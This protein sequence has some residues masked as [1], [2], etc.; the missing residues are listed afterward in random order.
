MIYN[1]SDAY[2][3]RSIENYGEFSESEVDVFREIL[4]SGDF[5]IDVGANIGCHT[6]AFQRLVGNTGA[7]FSFEPERNN[8]VTLCGNVA[9]NNLHNV[10]VYQKALGSTSGT[11]AVPEID[12]AKTTN[13]GS[14][15]LCHDYSGAVHYRV[16]VE[17]IDSLAFQKLSL[18]KI[19]VEGMEQ[20]V[21]QGA[22]ETIDRLKPVLYVE[23]DRPEKSESLIAYLKSLG[24][25]L[26][27]HQ[28]RMFNPNNYYFKNENI[29][30]ENRNGQIFEIFSANLLCYH[31]SKLCPVDVTKHGMVQV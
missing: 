31:E 9:V 17:T 27:M 29:F 22:A 4:A 11:I 20:T 25:V 15:S 28:A 26:F 19:D 10:W 30:L 8:F 16:P 5:V 12:L 24:Y 21:L 23:N 14:L 13:Y 6:L 7:V 18:L 1:N 2:V 3:G